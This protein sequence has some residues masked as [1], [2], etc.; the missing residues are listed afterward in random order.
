[1]ESIRIEILNPKVK[2]L[3]KDLA[4]LKLIRIDKEK[5][6]SELQ[7]LLD[8]FRNSAEDSISIEDITSEVDAVR[9]SRYEK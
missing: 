8:K 3:L 7:E 2:S 1:M 5:G 9:K 4:D 6:K